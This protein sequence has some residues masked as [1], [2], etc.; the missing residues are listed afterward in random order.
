[1]ASFRM[2]NAFFLSATC[3]A[4]EYSKVKYSTVQLEHCKQ[5]DQSVQ[6][7]THAVESAFVGR[8]PSLARITD[9]HCKWSALLFGLHERRGQVGP[10]LEVVR[11]ERRRPP[12][13]GDGRLELPLLQAHA[14]EREPTR[15]RQRV[16]RQRFL[17]ALGRALQL[18][19]RKHTI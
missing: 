6:N 7:V 10:G 18:Y 19:R 13:R 3:C 8:R 16:H 1:M 12:E 15:G 11:L 14:A 2:R 4:V 17:E 9:V 5:A